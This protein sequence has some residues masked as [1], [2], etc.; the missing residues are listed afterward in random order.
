MKPC[1][2]D[3]L[4]QALKQ[5]RHADDLK[6]AMAF[7]KVRG[8]ESCFHVAKGNIDLANRFVRETRREAKTI[9]LTRGWKLFMMLMPLKRLGYTI[10]KQI[11]K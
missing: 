11:D 5:G 7:Q 10:F 9:Q 2:A 1:S 8:V 6:D 3:A 4:E